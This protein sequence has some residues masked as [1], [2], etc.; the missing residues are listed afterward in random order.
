[1]KYEENLWWEE[2]EIKCNRGGSTLSKIV[3]S[4]VWGK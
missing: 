3:L 4:H 1:M 2:E